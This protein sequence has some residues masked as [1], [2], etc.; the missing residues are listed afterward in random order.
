MISRAVRGSRQNTATCAVAKGKAPVMSRIQPLPLGLFR[1]L[2]LC[3]DLCGGCQFQPGQCLD[4]RVA[5]L[6]V[7]PRHT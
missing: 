6:P 2:D 3:G 5:F 1:I 4:K 7:L